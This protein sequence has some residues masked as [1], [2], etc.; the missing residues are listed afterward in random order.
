MGA[1]LA[2]AGG[3][4]AISDDMKVR[5]PVIT[6]EDK[7]AVLQVLDSG[8]LWGLY[9]PQMRAL[10]K[11]FAEYIGVKFC[12]TMNSGTAALHA[13]VAAAGVGPGDEVITPAF[14]FLASAVAV[15]HHNAIPVFVDIDPRTFN[16]DVTKIEEKI[17]PRTKAI[18]PVHIHGLPA[19]MDEVLAIA[20]RHGLVV[21]EDA[22][23]AHGAIYKG[24]KAGS[25]GD[26]ATFSLNTTKNLPGGEGGFFV[27]DSEEYRGKA[28]MLRMF[29]EYV[30]P[31]EGRKYQ[32][33]TMGWNYRTQ[34]MP[35]AFTRSQLK[36][37]DSVNENARRNAEYLTSEL[38]KIPGVI[39]PYVPPD[40][41]SIYHKYRI[42]LNP[43]ALGLDVPVSEFR[44]KVQAAL[45]AEGVD[46]V[47]WQ[48]SP[49][50]GQP[51][52]QIMEGY[53]KGCPWTCK[54]NEGV[55]YSYDP[56]DYPETVKLIEDSLVICSETYPI[57]CQ[58]MDLM[59]RYV[60]AF[61]KV[62]E[63]IDQVLKVE[64][65]GDEEQVAGITMRKI[66]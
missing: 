64:V 61:Y 44:A 48:T 65:T 15:L 51:L 54:F 34:E 62:F 30:K 27:T 35:C 39:P 25:I 14:S 43:A 26:M 5:W 40:R 3:T 10:E 9:A 11:E 47:R 38:S 42:R 63:N 2:I 31:N 49:I 12:L 32:A 21:I 18:M 24:R 50:P 46:A 60:E 22:C 7:D 53:G 19:D 16:I 59:K 33:Y 13:A 1:S 8:I 23:Q 6:H 45:Q 37:L 58:T 41:T 55:T 4:K 17:T 57:Y 20:K 56:A 52:F 28:N 36:R 66:G 29:G